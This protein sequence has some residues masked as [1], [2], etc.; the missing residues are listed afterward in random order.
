[1]TSMSSEV[2]SRLGSA[3][4]SC[5]HVGHSSLSS[6]SSKTRCS[7]GQVGLWLGPEL[8]ALL[9]QFLGR[10]LGGLD[11]RLRPLG[12]DERKRLLEF[13]GALLVLC[14]SVGLPLNDFKHPL[15]LAIEQDQRRCAIARGLTRC[16]GS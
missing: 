16:G 12:L 3:L 2:S 15:E 9:P 11:L 5:P 14:E 1:M 7:W 13:V 4:R 8:F 10:W 6:G